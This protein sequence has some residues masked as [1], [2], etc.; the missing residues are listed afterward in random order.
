MS[1]Y[2]AKAINPATGEVEGCLFLDNHFGPNEYG[3]RFSDGTMHR[4]W[5][6]REVDTK[7]SEEEAIDLMRRLGNPGAY[8][9]L[10][11]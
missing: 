7:L 6:I 9:A 8:P 2:P 11:I 5:D 3:V 4:P 1:D 10:G